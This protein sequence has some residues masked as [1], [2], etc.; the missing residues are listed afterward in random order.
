MP[1]NSSADGRETLAIAAPRSASK[2]DCRIVKPDYPALSR[3][4]GETGTADVR[5]VVG[6]TG[7]IKRVE[8]AKSS[9]FTRLDEAALAAM[10]ASSCQPYVENGTPTPAVYTQPFGFALDE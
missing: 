4:R 9:G 7:I 2:I 6:P 1:A 3:R 10:R 5:F 8:L